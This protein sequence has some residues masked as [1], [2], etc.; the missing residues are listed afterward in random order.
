MARRVQV[1][2]SYSKDAGYF[3]RL[4]EAVEQDTAKSPQ[5]RRELLTHLKA[6][7][8]LMMQ[9]QNEPAQVISA[10]KGRKK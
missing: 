9:A 5:W 10:K 8:I 4:C 6:A 3:T 2:V 7:T 1:R